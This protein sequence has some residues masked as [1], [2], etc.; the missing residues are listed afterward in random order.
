MGDEERLDGVGILYCIILILLQLRQ[1][2]FLLYVY[3]AIKI[4]DLS[5]LDR[6]STRGS[7]FRP[8]G[9]FEYS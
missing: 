2:I 5:S 6:S 8:S 1:C 9:I 4:N 3:L 7:S